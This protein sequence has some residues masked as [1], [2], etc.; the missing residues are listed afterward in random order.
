[1]S[2]CTPWIRTTHFCHLEEMLEWQERKNDILQDEN[3][4]T[5]GPAWVLPLQAQG[6]SHM[7]SPRG[8]LFPVSALRPNDSL[9]SNYCGIC[10]VISSLEC[11]MRDALRG[12]GPSLG[13]L[14]LK[15]PLSY[16]GTG[17]SVCSLSLG[18]LCRHEDRKPGTYRLC[19]CSAD[20]PEGK[21]KLLFMHITVLSICMSGY[22]MYAWCPRWPEE[23]IQIP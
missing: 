23:G 4:W 16:E 1:M 9:A 19:C 10:S 2:H 17:H 14:H 22:H 15:P 18:S 3:S 8:S 6:N 5:L 21:L 7:A 20:K 11:L 13:H 12:Q